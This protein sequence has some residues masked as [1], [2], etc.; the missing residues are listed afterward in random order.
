[1]ASNV[2]KCSTCNIVINEVLAF[3]Q[4]KIDVMDEKSV[5]QICSTSFT[6]Q[7]ISEAKKLLFDS[8][9][10]TRLKVRKKEGKQ[11][12][13]LE[14]IISLL[15][16]VN[17]DE[18]PIFVARDLHKLPPVTFDHVDVT[19]LLKDILILQKELRHIKAHY[20]TKEDVEELKMKIENINFASIVNN[21]DYGNNFDCVNKKRGAQLYESYMY[22]SG[23][24]GLPPMHLESTSDDLPGKILS[25]KSQ[26]QALVYREIAGSPAIDENKNKP[27]SAVISPLQAASEREGDCIEATAAASLTRGFY[28]TCPTE[29]ETASDSRTNQVVSHAREQCTAPTASSN[30]TLASERVTHSTVQQN[31]P[32][33]TIAGA[34]NTGCVRKQVVGENKWQT[35]SYGKKKNRFHG[36]LG[37]ASITPNGKFK[38][39]DIKIPLF[40]SNVS[41]DTTEED[42]ISY[43]QNKAS[44]TVNL[45]KINM[46]TDRRY[47]SYKLYVPKEKLALFLDGDFWPNGITYRR[48]V[49]LKGKSYEN[50]INTEKTA[51]LEPST[52]ERNRHT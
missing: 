11:Q 8:V 31:K 28:T 41:K 17:P 32:T 10:N 38:S 40:I 22:D 25:P 39:V 13:D 36:K 51:L 1:M 37:K 29:I 46:K 52:T 15:K 50:G 6:I 27:S 49:Y 14:D 23:P 12:R 47:N 45:F 33:T 30:R 5:I 26:S 18:I 4:T 9:P 21:R 7:E 2:V 34:P 44:A 42:I 43:I 48:F 24:V 35:V 19:R 3:V 16:R 20:S